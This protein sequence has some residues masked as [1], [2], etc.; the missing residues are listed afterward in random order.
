[1]II[2]RGLLIFAACLLGI[3]ATGCS[4]LRGVTALRDVD[5]A[6]DSVRTARL[7]GIDVMRL[8]AVEELTPLQG[9]T[10]GAALFARNLPL[11]LEVVVAA[12]NPGTVAARLTRLDWTFLL[13]GRDTVA[14]RLDRAYPIPAGATTL[15]PVRVSLN[16]AEF[17]ERN[18]PE[19]VGL[20]LAA[21]GESSRPVELGLRIRPTVDTALGPIAMPAPITILRQRVG[22]PRGDATGGT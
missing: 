12:H 10:L 13:A 21:A 9:A 20:A 2:R 22:G 8:A 16:L 18:L 5:F 6:L 3:G 19:L 11:E 7:A 15:I 4:T 14:G 1:M 17:F